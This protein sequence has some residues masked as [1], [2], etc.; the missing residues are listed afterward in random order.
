LFAFFEEF[1][2]LSVLLYRQTEA[3][4]VRCDHVV[5]DA[6]QGCLPIPYVFQITGGIVGVD[7]FRDVMN[8]PEGGIRERFRNGLLRRPNCFPF[9]LRK[10]G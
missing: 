10:T 2:D 3:A 8:T 4:V 1:Y 9:H 7:D 5:D 6:F